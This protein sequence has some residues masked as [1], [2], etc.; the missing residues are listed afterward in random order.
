M[1]TGYINKILSPEMFEELAAARPKLKICLA[2]FD[3]H[4]V[5]RQLC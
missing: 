2:H 5:E 4:G 3:G 1:G